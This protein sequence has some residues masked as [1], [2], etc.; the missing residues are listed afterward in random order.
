[1]N[2]GCFPWNLTGTGRADRMISWRC[3]RNSVGCG[4][5]AFEDGIN[6]PGMC[7]LVPYTKSATE[8]SASSLQVALMPRS[9]RGSSSIQFGEVSLALR[10][11]FSWR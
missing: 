2:V 8:Q 11:A 7:R 5:C 10:D 9:T 6:S 1:M 3:W 4:E